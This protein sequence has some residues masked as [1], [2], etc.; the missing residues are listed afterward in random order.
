MYLVRVGAMYR[1]VF[2]TIT[3]MQNEKEPQHDLCDTPNFHLYGWSYCDG[4][5]PPYTVKNSYP[6]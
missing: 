1:E 5:S 3:E 2:W 6:V 4:A